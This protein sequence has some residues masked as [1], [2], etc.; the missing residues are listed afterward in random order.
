MAVT[1]T[2]RISGDSSHLQVAEAAAQAVLS[3]QSVLPIFAINGTAALALL[4]VHKSDQSAAQRHYSYLTGHRN[5]SSYSRSVSVESRPG[6][7]SFAGEIVG[8]RSSTRH[9][10]APP[11]TAP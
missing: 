3:A 2:A 10:N 7:A 11:Q 1:A 8:A 5:T 4:A 9:C 6:E